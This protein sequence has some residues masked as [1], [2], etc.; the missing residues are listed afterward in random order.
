[1]LSTGVFT[2]LPIFI[3]SLSRV[4]LHHFQT[5][6]MASLHISKN[7]FRISDS[8]SPILHFHFVK[9]KALWSFL[10]LSKTCILESAFLLTTHCTYKGNNFR[11]YPFPL[12]RKPWFFFFPYHCSVSH[13]LSSLL[14]FFLLSFPHF[15]FHFSFCLP[16]QCK[17]FNL[18]ES[19]HVICCSFSTL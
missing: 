15:C 10:F 4:I 2:F 11:S 1:M 8:E 17:D 7:L 9:H 14:F 5:Q 12:H 6:L 19:Y 16:T 18:F 13:S 3:N